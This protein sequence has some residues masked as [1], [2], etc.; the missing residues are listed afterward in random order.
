MPLL[1][2]A[3]FTPEAA[4]IAAKSGANRIEFC[5]EVETGG[6]TPSLEDFIELRK[7]IDIP[8]FVM[9]RSRAGDYIYDE[10]D[11]DQMLM[12]LEAFQHYGADGFV[13][14][15]VTPGNM[16]DLELCRSLVSAADNLPCTYHRAFDEIADWKL[17]IDQLVGIGMKRI[18]TSGRAG[19]APQHAALI[20][21][22]KEYAGDRI[23]ILPGGGLRSNNCAELVAAGFTEFH[24][25]AITSMS[26]GKPDEKEIS[27]LL[28]AIFSY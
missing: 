23:T 7:Q 14:G 16:P 25:S 26:D 28:K 1:E 19:S 21:E 5:A 17:A 8:I 18:L 12:E 3:C 20:K 9:I 6:L 10:E 2:I 22:M 27:Q 4:L 13:I 24:S 15:A 11:A